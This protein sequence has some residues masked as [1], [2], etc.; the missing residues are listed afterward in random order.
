[1]K[2]LTFNRW[3]LA[4]AAGGLV[5]L[6]SAARADE[7]P[8]A[9]QTALSDTT[10]SGYVSASANVALTGDYAESPAANIPFQPASKENGFNLDVVKLVIARPEDTNT[11]SA[12]YEVDLLFGPDAVGYNTSA[13]A[14]PTTDYAIKQAFITLSTPIGNGLDWKIG[15]FDSP[16]GYEVYDVGSNPNYTHSWGYYVEPTELTGLQGTYKLNDEWSLNAGV[17]N[18]SSAGI[19]QR[20]TYPHD[21][22]HKAAFGDVTYTAPSS[23]GWAAGSALFAGVLYGSVDTTSTAPEPQAGNQVNYYGGLTLNTPW[24]ALT[25]GLAF[26]YV[27]N[28]ADTGANDSIFG[29]YATYKATDKLSFNA[30]GEYVET[31]SGFSHVGSE[32]LVELTGTVE[33]DLW[34]NVQSRVEVRWDQDLST[35]NG[36]LFASRERDSVGLYAN[37]IYKF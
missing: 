22:W 3:T 29:L 28:Y 27:Q 14:S 33:Y 8:S 21:V 36:D 26:D 12:G 10:I 2:Q 31:D 5:S 15:V 24:K 37:I 30:R 6:T 19:N 11:W 17:A 20:N 34:A 16:L 1:M 4:L 35:K 9:V 7:K 25:G 23:W 18:T 32:N 13:N